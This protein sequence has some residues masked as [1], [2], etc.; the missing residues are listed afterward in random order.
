MYIMCVNKWPSGYMTFLHYFNMNKL[1]F[2]I[3]RVSLHTKDVVFQQ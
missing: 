1:C 3:V 2:F